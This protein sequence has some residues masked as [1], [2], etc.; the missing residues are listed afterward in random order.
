[1]ADDKKSDKSRAWFFTLNNPDRTPLEMHSDLLLL[2]PKSFVFQLEKGEDGTPHYQGAV[3]C[4]NAIRMPLQLNKKIHWERCKSWVK[5]VKYCSKEETRID[6][7]WTYNCALPEK[8]EIITVLKPWQNKV[9]EILRGKP[10][11]R[12]ILWLWE[13]TGNA[14]KTAMAKWICK[15]FE[16]IYLNGKG[17]DA[18]YAVQQVISKGKPLDVVVFGYPRSSA[19]YVNYGCIEEIKDG[20]FFSGKYEAGMVMYN[21][22][23]VVVFSNEQPDLSKMSA[24]RWDIRCIDLMDVPPNPVLGQAPNYYSHFQQFMHDVINLE[25]QADDHEDLDEYLHAQQVMDE[26]M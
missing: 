26:M 21:S 13:P 2:E 10:D 6:G 16:A 14:G 23:H 7:P 12:K 3:Y 24:D 25:T 1:M 9:A 20:I 5:A 19:E 8:L 17:T 4:K 22:P 18:K 15:H 11:N